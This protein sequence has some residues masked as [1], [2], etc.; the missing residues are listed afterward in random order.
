[1]FAFGIVV[2][3]LGILVG[4]GAIQPLDAVHDP[5]HV[6]HAGDYLG[7]REQIQEGG[8]L[9]APQAIGIEHNALVRLVGVV[10]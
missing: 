8:Q 5:G 10:A 7:G 4:V 1:V 3:E 2:E 9:G 6:A